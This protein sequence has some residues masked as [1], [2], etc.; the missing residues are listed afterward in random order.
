MGL[1]FCGESEESSTHMEVGTAGGDLLSEFPVKGRDPQFPTDASLISGVL[2]D[3]T[4]SPAHLIGS[5]RRGCLVWFLRILWS[6]KVWG[7]GG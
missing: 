3:Q 7:G 2:I 6:P 5:L 1:G 4:L